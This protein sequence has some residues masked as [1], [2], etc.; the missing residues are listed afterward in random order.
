MGE[1]VQAVHLGSH[2]MHLLMP[3]TIWETYPTGHYETQAP[4]SLILVVL[5][6]ILYPDAHKL[7]PNIEQL[8]QFSIKS[9][10]FLHVLFNE[11]I[12][13]GQALTQEL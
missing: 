8:R 7:Q 3:F 6:K 10:H 9:L 4:G 2:G 5:E 11:I 12:F 13:A 1:F